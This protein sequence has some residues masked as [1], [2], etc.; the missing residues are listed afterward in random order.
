VPYK[1]YPDGSAAWNNP[2]WWGL[3]YDGVFTATTA[4]N[5]TFTT[6]DDDG[7]AIWIDGNLLYDDEYGNK[8]NSVTTN[9][10]TTGVWAPVSQ[11]VSLAAGP[12]Q[13]MIKYY[14]RPKQRRRAVFCSVPRNPRPGYHAVDEFA[15]GHS[16]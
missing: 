6:Y 7:S 2:A 9:A 4:G 10:G 3:C 14:S 5:Y 13:V 15:R 16:V 11:S 12:H 8:F 1:L